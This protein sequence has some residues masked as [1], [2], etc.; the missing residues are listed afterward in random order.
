MD[1]W[2]SFE[3]MH[4]KCSVAQN[5]SG[6]KKAIC[7]L[8]TNL[9]RFLFS[10]SLLICAQCCWYVICEHNFVAPGLRI[11]IQLIESFGVKCLVISARVSSYILSWISLLVDGLNLVEY[12]SAGELVIEISC[13]FN[14][15]RLRHLQKTSKSLEFKCPIL[16]YFPFS[17]QATFTFQEETMTNL[18][19]W[20][21][22]LKVCLLLACPVRPNT[23]PDHL[24]NHL[25][26]NF[27]LSCVLFVY[28]GNWSSFLWLFSS[29]GMC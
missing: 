29:S 8:P 14:N 28:R 10:G 11:I 6:K 7:I 20:Y 4:I 19:K 27:M 2:Y 12:L 22:D 3:N 13:Y 1:P 18:W 15:L 17:Y 24:S 25:K 16:V 26:F 9:T 23:N 5:L 21:D